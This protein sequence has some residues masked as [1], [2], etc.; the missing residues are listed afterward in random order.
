MKSFLTILLLGFSFFAFSQDT[1]PKNELN[2]YQRKLKPY[3]I[4]GS[5]NVS[6]V[7]LYARSERNVN[8]NP[9]LIGLYGQFSYNVSKRWSFGPLAQFSYLK[10]T[11]KGA[12]SKT[13]REGIELS[14]GGLARF[15]LARADRINLFFDTYAM[16]NFDRTKEILINDDGASDS[17]IDINSYGTLNISVGMNWIFNPKWALYASFSPSGMIFKEGIELFSNDFFVRRLKYFVGVEY[18]FGDKS[19]KSKKKKRRKRRKK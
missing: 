17:L 3:S 14:A 2:D 18:S 9:A 16:Y 6:R 8:V 4:I 19:K 5:L 10:S 13:K 7:R 1:D 12:F 15:M 11:R